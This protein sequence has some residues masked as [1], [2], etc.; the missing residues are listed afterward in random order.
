[1]QG[2]SRIGHWYHSVLNNLFKLGIM[3]Y[4]ISAM[5]QHSRRLVIFMLSCSICEALAMSFVL[6]FGYKQ[7]IGETLRFYHVAFQLTFVTSHY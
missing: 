3:Q 5:Y 6:G 1:M 2:A 4:L 7:A